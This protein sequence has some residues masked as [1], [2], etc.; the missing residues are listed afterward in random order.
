MTSV[1]VQLA[2]DEVYRYNCLVTD[3]TC[4]RCEERIRQAL[5]AVPGIIAV[6]VERDG[7]RRAAEVRAWVQAVVPSVSLKRAIEEASV[8]TRHR[9][10]VIGCRRDRVSGYPAVPG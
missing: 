3:V 10:Q 1:S 8:G 4:V 6:E 2:R 5:L 9:Y 7:E